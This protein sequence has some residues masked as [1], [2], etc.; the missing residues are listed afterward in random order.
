MLFCFLG[1]CLGLGSAL[2]FVYAFGHACEYFCEYCFCFVLCICLWVCVCFV[3]YVNLYVILCMLCCG[4]GVFC[5][6]LLFSS[7]YKWAHLVILHP[8]LVHD[9]FC[10]SCSMN[11]SRL[12]S[13]KV[14]PGQWLTGRICHDLEMM[15]NFSDIH[16]ISTNELIGHPM[17]P[18]CNFIT[19]GK[20]KSVPRNLKKS[21]KKK[22]VEMVMYTNISWGISSECDK[23]I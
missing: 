21:E 15:G 16:S 18:W 19:L 9:S 20:Q 4:R 10:G 8:S 1:C 12:S 5:W 23:S 22:H 6:G 2:V 11:L 17:W 7:L 13:R 3:L 14:S